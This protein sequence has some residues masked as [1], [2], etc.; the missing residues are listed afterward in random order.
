M[1]D[2][3][4]EREMRYR[5]VMAV[6]RTMLARGLIKR[7][8]FEDFDRKMTDKY[9]PFFVCLSAKTSVDKI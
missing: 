3:Q 4:F 2:A 6:A 8:E 1:T 9:N 7:V 5:T